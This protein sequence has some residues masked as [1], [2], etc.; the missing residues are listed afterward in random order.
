[1]WTAQKIALWALLDAVRGPFTIHTL[2]HVGAAA[3]KSF[4]NAP[5]K[6]KPHVIYPRKPLF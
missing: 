5:R 4:A 2:M 6:R 1:L 3:H